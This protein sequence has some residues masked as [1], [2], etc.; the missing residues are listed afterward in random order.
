MVA[1]TT[2]RSS[3]ALTNGNDAGRS[4]RKRNE[5]RAPRRDSGWYLM[6]ANYLWVALGGALGSVARFWFSLVIASRFGESFPLGTL[7]VN[8]TGSVIIG[9]FATLT[10][11]AAR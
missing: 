2:G 6:I 4:G 1:N 7:F 3:S 11:P 10:A 5:F 9:V 8:V